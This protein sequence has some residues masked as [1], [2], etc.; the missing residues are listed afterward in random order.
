MVAW[1]AELTIGP[2]YIGR[3]RVRVAQAAHDVVGMCALEDHA[4]HWMLEHVWIEPAWHGRGVGRALVRDALDAARRTRRAV[5]R[6]VADPSA[7]GFYARLGARHVG[8]RR[9]PMEGAA[10]RVLPIMEF[11]PG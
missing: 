7:A 5:V 8:D 10:D 2:D 11:V 3:H 4:T 6:L 9:A 1:T